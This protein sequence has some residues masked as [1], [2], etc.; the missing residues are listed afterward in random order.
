MLT[1][2]TALRWS[3]PLPNRRSAPRLEGRAE[4]KLVLNTAPWVGRQAR[5]Y[6][7]MPAV[8][9]ATLGIEWRTDGRLL[10]GRLGGGQRQLVFQGV[11]PSPRLEDTLHVDVHA[12]ARDP[13]TPSQ[14]RYTFTIEVPSL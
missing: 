4:V 7:A 5:I 11:V 8:A 1:P 9:P 3:D 10:P 14:I 6:M 12:D 13:V 2:L